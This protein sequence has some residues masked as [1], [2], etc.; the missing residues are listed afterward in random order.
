MK[1]GDF[2]KQSGKIQCFLGEKALENEVLKFTTSGMS[3]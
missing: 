1:C 2:G 3:P